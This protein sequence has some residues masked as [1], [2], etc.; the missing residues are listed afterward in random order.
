MELHQEW[1][2]PSEIAWSGVAPSRLAGLDAQQRSAVVTA[3]AG[4]PYRMMVTNGNHHDRRCGVQK[5]FWSELYCDCYVGCMDVMYAVCFQTA[6]LQFCWMLRLPCPGVVVRASGLGCL[7]SHL[8]PS[9]CQYSLY[10][11]ILMRSCLGGVILA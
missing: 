8:L 10:R 11:T 6:T 7:R 3:Q 1:T 2:A 4:W 9:C 5:G